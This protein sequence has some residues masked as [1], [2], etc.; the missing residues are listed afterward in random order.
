[1]RSSL[2]AYLVLAVLA[3]VRWGALLAHP[4]AGRLLGPVLLGGLAAVGLGRLRRRSARGAGV[5]VALLLTLPIAG[6][7]ISWLTELRL[8]RLV[9]LI[10]H[11]LGT[12]PGGLVPVLD[13]GP[14]R[15]VILL[16]GGLLVV[17]GGGLAAGAERGGP[18]RRAVPA[19][20]LLVLIA[21]PDTLVPSGLPYLEGAAVLA[22]LASMAWGPRLVRI[23]AI[24]LLA[25]AAVLAAVLAPA[26]G[27]SRPWFD[28]RHLAGS[29]GGNA[30]EQFDFRQT[31]GSLDW[32]R[33]GRRLFTVQ[34]AQPEYWKVEDLDTFDGRGFVPSPQS[35][36]RLPG[37]DPVASAAGVLEFTVDDA[38]LLS[39][40]LV[41]AGYGLRVVGS[42]AATGG[43][44]PGTFAVSP[45][46][47]PG[48]VYAVQ[49]YVPHP[50]AA[51]LALAGVAEDPSLAPYRTI[52]LPQGPAVRFA[53][54]HAAPGSA[55]YVLQGSPYARVYALARRLAVAAPTPYAFVRSVM[56]D[57]AQGYA[58]DEHP[59][60]A[61]LPLV[62]FLFSARRGYCQ[63][64][65]GAMALLLRMGGVPA[66]VVGGFTPGTRDAV[67]HAWMVTDQDAHDWVEAWFPGWGWVTFDPTPG[68]DP[69][70]AGSVPVPGTTP[71][72]PLST[73]SRTAPVHRSATAPLRRHE[74]RSASAPAS[75]PRARS[76]TASARDAGLPLALAA[77]G[78]LLAALA[79]VG[80]RRAGCV[81]STDALVSE[82][83]RALR[84]CGRAPV[85]GTT[86]AELERRF[87][88]YAGAARYLRA[89]R[90]ARYAGHLALPRPEDRRALRAALGG[91]LGAGGRLRAWWALPPRPAARPRLHSG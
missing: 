26:L 58:Y 3:A 16:G 45:P 89:L 47:E 83:E 39:P 63:Q 36:G 64:F 35:A 8:A 42:F 13:D 29:L 59:P 11:G 51:A 21:I 37:P 81:R 49:A 15:F 27:S 85:G 43:D 6:V 48:T 4:P 9:R 62:S 56:S 24:G 28:V 69:A 32:P 82:L 20:P 73:R 41:V 75:R 78:L 55:A 52:D 91:G 72:V 65:A 71:P 70:L 12:I 7:P 53:P 66:R 79:F 60:P 33:T 68:V 61:R 86:L 76:R 38:A 84:R 90:E 57:L 34:A 5:A 30:V 77:L 40:Q 88:G 19:L 80:W 54:F 18:W 2:V 14:L 74:L 46:L 25:L 1:M 17:L 67:H 31:F 87:G 22:L 44:A 10:G 23:P 50:S